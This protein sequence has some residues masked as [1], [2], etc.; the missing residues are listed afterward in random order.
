MTSNR[1]TLKKA[2]WVWFIVI[3]ILHLSERFAALWP[4]GAAYWSLLSAGVLM[5][6]PVLLG[7]RHKQKLVYLDWCWRDSGKNLKV[8]GLV[9]LVVFPPFLLANHFY[10]NYFF[11]KTFSGIMLAGAPLYFFNHLILVALPEEIFFRGYLEGELTKVFVPK[12]KLWGAPFGWGVILSALIFAFSHSL[13][14]F[15]WWHFSIF[16]PALLFS[17][18]R[19]KTGS[20]W[21]AVLFHAVCNVTSYCILNSYK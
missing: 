11:H 10:Q 16:F 19:Q 15:Q 20:V 9:C 5:Y 3:A 17:W 18:L 21:V 12:A 2:A 6:T 4:A 7:L 13:I 8:L 14:Q 1:Q